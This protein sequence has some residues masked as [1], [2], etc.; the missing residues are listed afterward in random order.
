M[1]HGTPE[2]LAAAERLAVRLDHLSDAVTAQKIA[3]HQHLLA[4]YRALDNDEQIFTH[5][6]RILRLVPALNSAERQQAAD[7]IASAYSSLARVA[8]DRAQTPHALSILHE[9]IAASPDL[10]SVVTELTTVLA[11][12]EQVGHPGAPIDAQYWFNAPA[13][14]TQFTP[15]GAVTLVEFTAHWCGPCR[16]SYPAIDRLQHKY[17]THGLQ[18]LFATIT[19]G[20][21]KDRQKLTAAQEAAADSAYYL[22]EHA[23]PV[24]VAV[25][26]AHP[27]GDT[28]IHMPNE[29]NYKVGGIPQIVLL[30]RAGVVRMIVVG[31]DPASEQ[32]LS[33]MLDTLFAEPSSPAK[34]TRGQ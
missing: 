19:Y 20:F 17:G 34:T 12:Y 2:G 22:T 28:T 27:G 23:L 30:D 7:A 32:H 21:F 9:G 25:Y 24:R 16:K 14:T 11:R 5:A 13:G 26:D 8:G 3:G 33:A 1:N 6:S 4:D 10:P 18:T 15:G 31:W 29:T